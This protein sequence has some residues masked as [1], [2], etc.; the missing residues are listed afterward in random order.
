MGTK[1]LMILTAR[2]TFFFSSSDKS[3]V[4]ISTC[5]RERV[6]DTIPVGLLAF[7]WTFRKTEA[8]KSARKGERQIRVDI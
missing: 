4:S 2:S 1:T 7:F 8:K 3:R 5:A 6:R